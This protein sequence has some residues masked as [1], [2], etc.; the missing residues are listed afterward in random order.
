[1]QYDIME[2][3]DLFSKETHPGSIYDEANHHCTLVEL[4]I[5]AASLNLM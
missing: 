2:V 4:S 3:H 1:M 5:D